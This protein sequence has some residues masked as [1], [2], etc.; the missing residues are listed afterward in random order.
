MG[1]SVASL[2]AIAIVTLIA[3]LIQKEIASGL[4]HASAKRLSRALNIA[5]VP[6]IVVFI[7]TVVI[8]IIDVLR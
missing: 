4:E 6:L 5:L 1:A 3:M 7:T 8:D 2:A